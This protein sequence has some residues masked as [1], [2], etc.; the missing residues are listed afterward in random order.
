MMNDY[1][2]HYL[3]INI[4]V[5]LPPGHYG[6]WTVGDGRQDMSTKQLILTVPYGLYWYIG[7]SQIEFKLMFAGMGCKGSES[8]M[9]HG[10]AFTAKAEDCAYITIANPVCGN[11]FIFNPISHVCSCTA[12][13]AGGCD[14]EEGKDAGN[15]Y[16]ITKRPG[17]PSSYRPF[18]KLE[19]EKSDFRKSEIL[20][21]SVLTAVLGCVI[22]FSVAYSVCKWKICARN[23][24][25][26]VYLDTMENVGD[27]NLLEGEC[28]I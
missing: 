20:L 9:I 24:P 28:Q 12:F 5:N 25:Y 21:W 2:K 22:G 10:E 8:R 16:H 4:G 3:D 7:H 15:V 23:V 6:L 26:D 19:K 14:Y 18:T 17:K 27:E 13:G 1:M 11:T